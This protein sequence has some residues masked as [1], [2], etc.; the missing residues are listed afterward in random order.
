MNLIYVA[1]VKDDAALVFIRGNEIIAILRNVGGLL[2]RCVV[3]VV[4]CD[5]SSVVGD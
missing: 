4:S 1:Y 3:S 2:N 5:E